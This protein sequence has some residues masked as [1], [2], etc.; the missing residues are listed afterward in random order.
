M[1]QEKFNKLVQNF[2][3]ALR[4]KTLLIV[5]D[6]ASKNERAVFSLVSFKDGRYVNYSPMLRELGFKQYRQEDS[7]F[8]TYCAGRFSLYVLDNIGNEL[9][10]KCIELPNDFY[11]VIQYQ[12]CI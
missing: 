5:I 11:S 12:N 9:R 3:E 2:F 10:G 1:E 7:L 8:V 4:Q 6:T